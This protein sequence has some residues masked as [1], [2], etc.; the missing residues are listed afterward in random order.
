[1]KESNGKY[2]KMVLRLTAVLCSFVETVVI[3]R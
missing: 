1:M 2:E 3:Q